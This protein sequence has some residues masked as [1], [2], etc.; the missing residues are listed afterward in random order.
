MLLQIFTITKCLRQV[1]IR[2]FTEDIETFSTIVFMIFWDFRIVE[3]ISLS[4][5]VKQSVIFKNKLI[6][7]S[8]LKRC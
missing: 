8:C 6:Y 4:A 3:Q 5:Q 7:T 1:L 2:P